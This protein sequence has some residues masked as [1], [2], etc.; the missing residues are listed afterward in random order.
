MNAWPAG[1]GRGGLARSEPVER[2]KPA[3]RKD[4]RPGFER[5]RLS[6]PPSEAV[7]GPPRD[8]VGAGAIDAGPIALRGALSAATLEP[9]SALREGPG[10]DLD[11]RSAAVAPAPWLPTDG[12]LGFLCRARA[13]GGGSGAQR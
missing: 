9:P 10:R 8:G 6:R 1:P 7:L 11:R 3:R 4:E 2:F 13:S 12:D 5:A